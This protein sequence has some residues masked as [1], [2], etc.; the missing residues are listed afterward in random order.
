MYKNGSGKRE[1]TKLPVNR[2][3]YSDANPLFKMK[4]FPR[5]G[6]VMV[7]L[8]KHQQYQVNAFWRMGCST[9]VNG[10]ID[11]IVNPGKLSSHSHTIVGGSNIGIDSSYESMINS[12]CTSCEIQADKSAYWAPIL[13]V[14]S[15]K[16]G[17][18]HVSWYKFD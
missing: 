16:R 10:R 13:Y 3:I 1:Q 11:P 12:A 5:F 9:I 6:A 17:L 4:F 15:I 2:A 8:M 18:R 14:L 7:L